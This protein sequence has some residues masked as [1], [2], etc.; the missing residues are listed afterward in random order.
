MNEDRRF[1]EILCEASRNKDVRPRRLVSKLVQTFSEEIDGKLRERENKEKWWKE[2]N[3]GE[4]YN[5]KNET[6]MHREKRT[7]DNANYS[8]TRV[9]LEMIRPDL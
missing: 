5:V 2:E 7:D 4:E 6:N 9:A 1:R 8:K 3:N